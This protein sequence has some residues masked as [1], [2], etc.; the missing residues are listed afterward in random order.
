VEFQRYKQMATQAAAAAAGSHA[1]LHPQHIPA[2]A[3]DVELLH[4]DQ[5]VSTGTASSSTS[6]SSS[7]EAYMRH[8]SSSSSSSTGAAVEGPEYQDRPKRWQRLQ[9][10]HAEMSER[11]DGQD[12]LWFGKAFAARAALNW[13]SMKK[14][15][16]QV[17]ESAKA[18]LGLQPK[19]EEQNE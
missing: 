8:A 12:P 3:R 13:D 6:P 11:L 15:A 4:A 7:A 17:V 5:H 16:G 14:M 18:D 2:V 10:L 9:E 19:S 1:A